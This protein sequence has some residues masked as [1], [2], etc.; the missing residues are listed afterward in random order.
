MKIL[1]QKR[2]RLA[3]L[4]VALSAAKGVVK[5]SDSRGKDE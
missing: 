3:K 5:Y 2:C 4:D 1:V